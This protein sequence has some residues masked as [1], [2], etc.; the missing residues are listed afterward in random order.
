MMNRRLFFRSLAGAPLAA[1]TA[2]QPPQLLARQQSRDCIC[3]LPFMSHGDRSGSYYL[4]CENPHCKQY[5]IPLA[6][7]PDRPMRLAD[8][9]L[10]RQVL[11]REAREARERD[12]WKE[13]MVREAK[14]FN[15]HWSGCRRS[16]AEVEY[17]SRTILAEVR[18]HSGRA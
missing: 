13:Q 16:E 2:P 5:R 14:A 6:S 15:F 17:I 7:L 3:G 12:A 9:E 18:K 10:V 8:P 4:T 1:K 11:E